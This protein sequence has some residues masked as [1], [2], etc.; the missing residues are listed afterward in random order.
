MSKNYNG[1][2]SFIPQKQAQVSTPTKISLL[3]RMKDGREFE[4]LV[5]IPLNSFD[6]DVI[7]ELRRASNDISVIRKRPN[8]LYF[9]N[10]VKSGIKSDVSIQSNDDLPFSELVNSI[11]SHSQEIDVIIVTP[12]GRGEQVT[13]FVDKLRP[14]FLNVTF[15][16]PDV[17][18]SA[19]TI[20]AMSGDEIIMTNNSYIGPIDPQVPNREGRFVPAQGILSLVQDIQKR[21]QELVLR[22][23]NPDWTDL[24][25]LRNIDP[26]EIGQ[27]IGASKFSVELVENYL[28]N[29]KFKTWTTHSNGT[30]V[31][32]EDKRRRANEIANQLCDHSLWKSHGRGITREVAWETCSLKITHSERIVGLD[33]AIKRLWAL[34]YWL[35]ENTPIFKIFLS[36]NYV[37]IRNENIIL[38]P[39][40]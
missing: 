3:D 13:R 2:R 14:R 19:G 26:K 5:G 36:Q 29:Y 16:I 39:K 27:A 1:N 4:S 6:V 11:S 24:Q 10:M 34:T 28:F 32:V 25:I 9:A 7:G 22:G 31:T 8:I 23:Q 21:G 15:I 35:F 33:R 40:N 18:M 30:V 17:A 38:T 12:G 37:I 20:F